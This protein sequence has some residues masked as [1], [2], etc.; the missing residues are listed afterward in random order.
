MEV[1]SSTRLST[2]SESSKSME[3]VLLLSGRLSITKQQL[4]TCCNPTCQI[5]KLKNKRAILVLV[6]NYLVISTYYYLSV[7]APHHS[8][9]YITWG[10][11]LPIAGWLADVYLGR[12]NVIRWSMWI[13]WVASMLATASSVVAQLVDSYYNISKNITI[14]LL[15][16]TSVGFGGYQANVILFG[17]DQLHDASSEEIVTFISWYVWTYFSGG[18]VIYFM[19]TYIDVNEE[20]QLLGQLLVCTSLTVAVGS[21]LL[22]NTMLVKEP[23]IQNPFKLVYK[24]LK[25]AIKNKHPRCRSAFTYCE[26]D[27]PPRIDFG[28]SKY[29]GPFTTEQV[30]DVKTFLRQLVIVCV[31]CASSSGVL[32]MNA[33]RNKLIK[34]SA[35][36]DQADTPNIVHEYFLDSFYTYTLFY[37]GAVLIPLHE[38][39]FHPVLQKYFSWVKSHWKI[40]LG[41]I[42]QMARVITLMAFVLTARHT[43]LL[44]HRDYNTTIN[45]IFSEDHGILRFS[46]N[47]R[48]MALPN[49]LNCM[50]YITIGIGGIEFICAQTPYSMRGLLF[51][52]VY[53]SVT[54]FNV[55]EYGIMQPFTRQL[56]FW[57]T[58]T[59]SCGFWYSL[60]IVLLLIFDSVILLALFK[61]YKRRKREDVLPNEQIFA[62]RYYTT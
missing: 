28:K 60:F 19:Y 18:I 12:Y 48:W 14:V 39:V 27:I 32:A 57:G 11:T 44:E 62:E 15:I 36:S 43:Y 25:Y 9:H 29:G 3:Q 30:E 61:W 52:A 17:I 26:D 31:G 4:N 54:I 6:W 33:L 53:G 55:I 16:I 20:Y 23:V 46:F 2:D 7:Y 50:S 40:S 56:S 59:I 35:Y 49:V 37:S 38:F 47:N 21:L 22:F 42:L 41:V 13:M 45:C 10:L 8:L 1:S 51:G 5:R 24:V 58:G 34:L